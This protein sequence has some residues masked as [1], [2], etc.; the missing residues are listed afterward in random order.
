M[1][2]SVGAPLLLLASLAACGAEPDAPAEPQQKAQTE[3]EIRAHA[4][5]IEQ[6]A[7]EAAKLIEEDAKAEVDAA[8]SKQQSAE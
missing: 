2:R 5:S 4:K 1:I 7:D 3:V 6:A 8:Q